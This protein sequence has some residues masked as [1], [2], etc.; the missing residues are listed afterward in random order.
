MS[1][2]G[3]SE[4][5]PRSDRGV[6]CLTFDN[7]GSAY[8]VGQRIRSAQDPDDEGLR[9]GYPNLLRLLDHLGLR[10]SFFIE[11]WNAIPN[12]DLVR[13]IASRG[14]EIGLHG[15]VHETFHVL[16]DIDAER[17]LADAQA[18]FRA[19]GVAPVGFRAPGGR[20]GR[21][22][23]TLLDRMGVAFDSSVDAEA[24]VTEPVLLNGRLPNVPWLWELIDYYQYHMHPEG[25]RSPEQ[26][27]RLLLETLE[28]TA[29]TRGTMTPIFHAHV[30]GI[31]PDRFGGVARFLNAAAAN[32]RIEILPASSVAARLIPSPPRD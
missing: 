6:V 31:A 9:R 16:D 29:D 23:V 10:A 11:G 4:H 2:P 19:I 18:A 26:Y 28:R 12:P 30:S 32:D 1:A 25:A 27:E 3:G 20:R 15:W 13:E 8:E 5:L 14:H 17:V 22:T 7:M 24:K 21:S